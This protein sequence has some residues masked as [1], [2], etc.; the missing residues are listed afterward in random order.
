MSVS[1]P[2]EVELPA[3]FI[4][5]LDLIAS[6]QLDLR[7]CS[8]DNFLGTQV[9][10]Y[11][12]PRAILTKKAAEALVKIQAELETSG[13][14][15]KVFDA[16]RPQRAVDQ[17]VRWANNSGDSSGKAE[18][19]PNIEKS[20]LIPEGYLAMKSSHSRGS[21]L[22]LTI[23]SRGPGQVVELD[24]GTQFD[25]FGSESWPDSNLVTPVQKANRI[26]LKSVMGRHGFLP[27]PTEWWH[28]TLKDEPYPDTYFDFQVE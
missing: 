15:I 11:L 25:Y 26:M 8:D 3:G 16:Y 1:R 22:D 6:I 10:G 9:D 7:Y 24:M 20:R 5:L 28:F 2:K 14:G 19:Y 18:Y 23:V 13:H 17:F 12:C 27:L 4:Y 21:T